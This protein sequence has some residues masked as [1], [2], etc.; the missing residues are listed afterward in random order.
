MSGVRGCSAKHAANLTSKT[1][2]TAMRKALS[3]PRVCFTKR[4]G[5]DFR[6]VEL[7]GGTRVG[8]SVPDGPLVLIESTKTHDE[9]ERN[10]FKS[11][12]NS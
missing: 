6:R 3:F 4:T 9:Y 5:S 2:S 7:V 10:S 1:R 11:N 8:V 12:N